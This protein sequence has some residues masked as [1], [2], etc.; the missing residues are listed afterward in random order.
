M[1][2]ISDTVKRVENDLEHHLHH[3]EAEHG[4]HHGH[5]HNQHH[6]PK[7]A[8]DTVMS[9][10]PFQH[11]PL[12]SGKAT[13]PPS[14]SSSSVMLSDASGH[15]SSR[16]SRHTSLK[17]R[18]DSAN[19]SVTLPPQPM[20][21]GAVK[22]P[23]PFSASHLQQQPQQSQQQQQQPTPLQ[24]SSTA[25]KPT[26]VAPIVIKRNTSFS[27]RLHNLLHRDKSHKNQAS[28]QCGSAPAHIRQS[29][30][31]GGHETP[32]IAYRTPT[33][34][35]S[36]SNDVSADASAATSATNSPPHSI[37]SGSSATNLARDGAVHQPSSYRAQRN[38]EPVPED[39][40]F[41]V[42]NTNLRSVQRHSN[43]IRDSMGNGRTCQGMD[44]AFGKRGMASAE[45]SA[46]A[47][48]PEQSL[49]SGD[50]ATDAAVVDDLS[51]AVRDSS[52]GL[53]GKE[54]LSSREGSARSVS[55]EPSQNTL[56][57]NQS[58]AEDTHAAKTAAES[59]DT[60][61]PAAAA[62]PAATSTTPAFAADDKPAKPLTESREPTL[63]ERTTPTRHTHTSS[64][65]ADAKQRLAAG[66]T[67]DPT[68]LP[69]E[70]QAS[71]MHIEPCA[72]MVPKKPCPIYSTHKATL[73]QFGRQTKV[74]GKGTGGTVRLLQ[75][76]DINARPPSL[77]SGPPSSHNGDEPAPYVPSEHKLFAVKEF[78][79][80]RP[81]E[82]PR[83][84]MKK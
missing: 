29:S 7:C 40:V 28:N 6:S 10:T 25:P 56:H 5:N 1:G 32:T 15:Q 46:T 18:T 26:A 53:T 71:E 43:Q 17:I 39:K 76:A 13:G 69:S 65:F 78:R 61:A 62:A 73:N 41:A 36:Q 2:I 42:S 57:R 35:T 75:G 47:R 33:S 44:D 11:S 59:G 68:L 9:Q 16:P 38:F 14:S 81:D 21:A 20:T 58:A 24:G 27:Q 63:A 12:A 19:Q 66:T 50:Y 22:P 30:A 67:R 49:S 8:Q 31:L 54:A 84:Y 48:A 4:A 72:A 3:H 23:S 77:R 74:I 83:A 64:E 60:I 45:A 80:R 79:K 51:Q 34:Q 55:R 37:N 70:N 82:T 52:F